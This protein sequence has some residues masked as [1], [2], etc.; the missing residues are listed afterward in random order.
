[1]VNTHTSFSLTETLCVETRASACGLVI[2]GAS[3]DLTERKLLPSLFSLFSRD[4]LPANFFILG[5]A[6]TP[7]GTD[8][9]REKARK[10]L[11]DRYRPPAE[12]LQEFC[13]RL[14]YLPGDY[15]D[16]ALYR[17]LAR[18]LKQLDSEQGTEGNLIFY[19][20]VPPSIYGKVTTNLA[21][22]ELLKEAPDDGRGWR[23]IVVEKPFGRDLASACRLDE[24]LQ[25][26]VREEQIYR[27]DHYL[28]KETVQNVL[29]LRFA[30]AIFEP[31]WNRN[32][33]DHIQI[34][35]AESI[36]IN[37]RAGYYENTGLLRDMFQNHMLQ[38]LCLV[39]MEPPVSFEADALRNEKAKLLQAVRPFSA[40][41]VKRWLVRGQYT[42][43]TV[44]DHEVCAYV[45]EENVSPESRI[46]TMVAARFMIDNWRWRGVPFYLRSGK[47]LNRRLT[48][49]A[50]VFKRVPHSIFEPVTAEHLQPNMLVMNVQPQEGIALNL[51]VK[52]PG[53]KLCMGSLEMH[54]NYRNLFGGEQ[55]EAYERLLLDVMLGD[56]TLFVRRDNVEMGW[57][58][59]MPVLDTWQRMDDDGQSNLHYY[60]AGTWGPATAAEILARDHRHWHNPPETN[61]S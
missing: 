32:F 4:L 34:T 43:G 23:R 38:L 50:V 27:I 20:S 16:P 52:Q 35:A 59:L 10:A 12:R 55:P 2:F 46:E 6:R 36:G 42:G 57:K 17:E 47:R 39:G 58:L 13:R 29:M 9:F 60:E 21:A 61:P 11:H 24:E 53:P 30:N 41:D 26:H 3:G 33:I 40:A 22:A 31:V 7:L 51:Q 45:D 18:K 48:E 19:L 1:M 15:A 25:R 44:D 56:Q 14:H 28:G 49:I 37:H 8:S 5:Y 54:M